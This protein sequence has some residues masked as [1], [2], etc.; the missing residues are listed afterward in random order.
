MAESDFSWLKIASFVG[1]LILVILAIV[2][3]SSGINMITTGNTFYGVSTVFGGIVCIIGAVLV[4]KNY[5]K[6]SL[7][8]RYGR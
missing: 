7:K 5:Q 6:K 1:A 4:Y 2:S 3:I 8:D